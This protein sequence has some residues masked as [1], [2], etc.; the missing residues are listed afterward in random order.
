LLIV[1]CAGK[2]EQAVAGG[3]D[4]PTGYELRI[5]VLGGF[6]VVSGERELDDHAWRLRKATAL[7]KL[8]ALTPGHR[9]HRERVID[10]LWPELPLTAGNNN[11]HR[12]LHA[13]RRALEPDRLTG[14]S[15][16]YLTLRGD[17]LSLGATASIVV[18]ADVFRQAAAAA[19][20]ARDSAAYRRAIA[21][22]GGDLLPDDLYNDW[23]TAAREQL[24]E[25]YISLLA[26]AARHFAAQRAPEEAIEA[27]R[28]LVGAEPTREDAHVALMR[29][30]ALGGQRYDALR[31][32]QQLRAVLHNELGAEP[33]AEAQRLYKEIGSGRYPPGQSSALGDATM[34]AARA[35]TDRRE[36]PQHTADEAG[37]SGGKARPLAV[38]FVTGA[39]ALS[40]HVTSFIGR[41]R[42]QEELRHRLKECRLVTIVG[43]GGCGK[44]RLALHIAEA[45]RDSFAD[46]VALVELG[47]TSD[48]ALV[49]QSVAFALGVREQA[50]RP[51]SETLAAALAP[52]QLLLVLDNCEHIHDACA[53]IVGQ[54]L[55]KCP[56]LHI[57]A[58]SRRPLG[59]AAEA[60][61][62][63]RPLATPNPDAL[64]PFERLL[65]YDAI[66]LFV[67]RA[68][69]HRAG[70]ALTPGN[71]PAA[72][73]ICYRL[74]GLP[75]AIELAA[76]RRRVLTVE[77]IA[78]RLGNALALLGGGPDEV[79]RQTTLRAAIA[80]SWDL[81]AQPERALLRRLAV[82]AGGWTIEAAEAICVGDELERTQ[83]LD[84][85][86]RLA[87]QSLVEVREREGT[88][89]YRLLETIRQYAAL[90]LREA[91]EEETLRRR[92]A[93]WHL[94]L[95]AAAE[96]GL[97][98]QELGQWL[99]RLDAES[100][101]L[102]AALA[103]SCAAGEVELA[104]RIAAHMAHYWY[105]RGTLREGRRW[106]QRVLAL[107]EAQGRVAPAAVRAYV[108]QESGML[109]QFQWDLA[110]AEAACEQSLRLWRKLDDR[111]GIDK[112]L[113][114]LGG[115]A[116][117][118]G[119]Y[120]R[121]AQ[122]YGECLDLARK[123]GD[124][125]R[126]TL[127]LSNVA[128][129]LRLLG[130]LPRARELYAESFALSKRTNNRRHMAMALTNLGITSLF[131]GDGAA[132][133][134]SLEAGLAIMRELGIPRGAGEALLPLGELALARG[135]IAQALA[136]YR[137]AL[138]E[139]SRSDAWLGVAQALEEMSRALAAE[140]Q[141]L[142][143]AR[144]L[145]TAEALRERL[146]TPRTP[147]EVSHY[148]EHTAALRAHLGDA[149]FTGALDAGREPPIEQIIAVLL[150]EV[151]AAAAT[152]E[153]QRASEPPAQ[154]A[155]RPSS[156]GARWATPV[157]T[158]RERQV[159]EL[160]ATG[161]TN[162]EIA[163]RLHISPRTT[164]T[165]VA[166]VL[167]KLNL[168]T[169]AEVGPRLRAHLHAE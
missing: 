16:R 57:L 132:A 121:A 53:R 74:D 34:R 75:L 145:G 47:A 86:A 116:E 69:A 128:D 129:Q 105:M 154:P 40:G 70:F 124:L 50:D 79:P 3:T 133:Q 9:L 30:Y 61:F 38:P 48:P 143:A 81:L 156:S 6:R 72:V 5:Q 15:A 155:Q 51:L 138:A 49:P 115:V 166:N 52:R 160:V 119:D 161:L 137:E 91:G 117:S 24:R 31:Q 73:R 159:A 148:Q 85:L 60:V 65:E 130:D 131:Q 104:S 33:D 36:M 111:R 140:D 96:S 168:R 54:L 90:R 35:T 45:Q 29:L 139:Y 13:A 95:V 17:T 147:R 123:L 108:L 66:R 127:G 82:F 107:D 80:W 112:S 102:R 135:A 126:V 64:P 125:S 122:L 63:L 55:H 120:Q 94:E 14:T 164:D 59:L 106:L 92:H 169:R 26:E 10:A 39:G 88:I 11:L 152:M 84:V 163:E 56:R 46:G 21:L 98:G 44:T 7:V 118:R 28:L 87:E 20:Q 114:V 165:H 23:T 27:L 110:G 77:Q 43:A 8:L 25:M 41:I 158:P 167:A 18:D 89:R 76:G 150:T 93:R 19:S 134:T 151:P 37:D 103:W 32:Y 4:C 2:G 62:R 142:S 146:G 149:A 162:R 153:D 144:V 22:Y 100:D 1:L 12:T 99:V 58:T 141:T 71:A 109:A 68:A 97:E 157:L 67:E 101:N 136:R 113:S 83:V 78:A 42:E